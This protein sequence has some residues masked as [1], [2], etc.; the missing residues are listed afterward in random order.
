MRLP[1]KWT[2]DVP[3]I[4]TVMISP[5]PTP[6]TRRARAPSTGAPSQRAPR[7]RRLDFA[8]TDGDAALD[9]IVRSRWLR[10]CAVTSGRTV[11]FRRSRQGSPTTS[12]AI[13]ARTA[14]RSKP[15]CRSSGVGLVSRDP[16][17][18]PD[19]CFSRKP[20]IG[21]RRVCVLDNGGAP[22]RCRVSASCGSP[23]SEVGSVDEPRRR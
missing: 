15:P 9:W 14:I 2:N 23:C 1:W 16:P 3:A 11:G 6:E 19:M 18:N 7:S 10:S 4:V 5:A 22:S 13:A 21:S 17:A 8:N 20:G 12:V